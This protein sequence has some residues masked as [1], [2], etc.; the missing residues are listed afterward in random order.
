MTGEITKRRYDL[1]GR[2]EKKEQEEK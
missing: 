1:I 2:I